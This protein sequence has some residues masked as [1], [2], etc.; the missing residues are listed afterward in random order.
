MRVRELPRYRD[1]LTVGFLGVT[2]GAG[3]IGT[4]I[5]NEYG[6]TSSKTLETV[7]TAL[8]TAEAAIFAVAFTVTLIGVELKSSELSSRVS[9]IF[10][11]VWIFRRTFQVFAVAI[12]FNIICL[13]I[14]SAIAPW[15]RTAAAAMISTAG[16]I[17]LLMIYFYLIE[18]IEKL[19]P[20]G[21]IDIFIELLTPRTYISEV[22]NRDGRTV[23][24]HPLDGLFDVVIE[25]NSGDDDALGAQSLETYFQIVQDVMKYG[26]YIPSEDLRMQ[27]Y[28]VPHINHSGF[29]F[30]HSEGK[31]EPNEELIPAP[32][33]LQLYEVLT[34]R[35]GEVGVELFEPVYKSHLPRLRD[36]IPPIDLDTFFDD[37]DALL[38][39]AIRNRSKL[40]VEGLF[41][42]YWTLYNDSVP[43]F[44]VCYK[45]EARVLNAT[46]SCVDYRGLLVAADQLE[47]L[48][49][50]L[51]SGQF[52]GEDLYSLLELYTAKTPDVFSKGLAWYSGSVTQLDHRIRNPDR[53]NDLNPDVAFI[54]SYNKSTARIIYAFYIGVKE[55]PGLSVK[56]L[57]EYL[58]YN[59]EAANE[60]GL[61]PEVEY[62]VEQ[63]IHTVCLL[64]AQTTADIESDN[65]LI[66]LMENEPQFAATISREVKRLMR[67]M[68]T[69]ELSGSAP[70]P[71]LHI[72]I[73]EKDIETDAL[74]KEV[75]K[76]QSEL[77]KLDTQTD[78]NDT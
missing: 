55:D 45:I 23:S 46:K 27:Q 18:A 72:D 61:Q 13:L 9:W 50:K 22:I 69:R 7:A 25:L 1:W 24:E 3:I 35:Y 31:L 76:L 5:A 11:R 38:I 70:T 20:G 36:E 65:Q 75:S 32:E 15:Q 33:M 12:L 64:S 14:G 59:I 49:E 73:P 53:Y 41:G 48:A 56:M 71:N 67:N 44:G 52:Q 74:R 77:A 17:T 21:V 42:A 4:L 29:F 68:R 40:L 39:V 78:R 54:V 60:T 58:E 16:A 10:T 57:I 63:F 34:I 51:S 47:T 37:I 19:T 43:S 62:L 8:L 66:S 26:L 6:S 28:L 2:L 30:L